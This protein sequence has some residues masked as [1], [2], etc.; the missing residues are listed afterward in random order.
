MIRTSN[1][2]KKEGLAAEIKATQL[3]QN[4]TFHVSVLEANSKGLAVRELTGLFVICRPNRSAYRQIGGLKPC[5]R[6][7]PCD[8]FY[9]GKSQKN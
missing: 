8:F 2:L 7:K 5:E 1:R 4:L 6:E 3:Q 9:L